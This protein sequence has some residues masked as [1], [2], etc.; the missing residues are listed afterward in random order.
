M[1][2][3]VTNEPIANAKISVDEI[4]KSMT[5]DEFGAY[6]R[7]LIPGSYTLRVSKEGLV[8]VLFFVKIQKFSE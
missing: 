5:I 7:L 6:W 4:D 1:T 8:F 3:V 2:D